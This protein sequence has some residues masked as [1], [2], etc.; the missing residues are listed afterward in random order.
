M[1][2]LEI[3]TEEELENTRN[4][5]GTFHGSESAFEIPEYPSASEAEDY[6][7]TPRANVE[8][9]L[10]EDGVGKHTLSAIEEASSINIPSTILDE[11]GRPLSAKSTS[12]F[13]EL[14]DEIDPEVLAP[15]RDDPTGE[16]RVTAERDE[17]DEAE[18][19]DI[20]VTAQEDNGAAVSVGGICPP[21]DNLGMSFDDSICESNKKDDDD[22]E[23]SATR[24]SVPS[25]AIELTEPTNSIP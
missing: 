17:E 4:L 1:K 14:D 24:Q 7:V 25:T 5:K 22:I 16:W 3:H 18:D 20:G 12:F 8:A 6:L 11:N 10:S 21:V 13:E 23:G 9:S 2:K 15:V 19:V